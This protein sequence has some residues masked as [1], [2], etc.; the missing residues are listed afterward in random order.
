MCEIRV[1]GYGGKTAKNPLFSTVSEDLIKRLQPLMSGDEILCFKP[2]F[3]EA[4][5][6]E[7]YD[8]GTGSVS[9]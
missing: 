6:Y 4:F 9:A 2:G 3:V 7:G 5:C 8:R 1:K